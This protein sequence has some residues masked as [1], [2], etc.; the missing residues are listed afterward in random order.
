LTAAAGLAVC[1]DPAAAAKRA[2]IQSNVGH[3]R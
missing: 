1:N 3:S 2:Q